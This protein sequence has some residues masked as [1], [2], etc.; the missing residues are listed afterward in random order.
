MLVNVL[1][2]RYANKMPAQ[3][4]ILELKEYHEISQALTIIH[5]TLDKV[6]NEIYAPLFLPLDHAFCELRCDTPELSYLKFSPEVFERYRIDVN[7]DRRNH[8]MW[9]MQN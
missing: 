4:I 5:D 7:I 6:A 1:L 8:M 9:V 3:E 2:E